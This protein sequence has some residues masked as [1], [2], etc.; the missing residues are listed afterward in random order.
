MPTPGW[1][2]RF[3][4]T[5]ALR[6]SPEPLCCIYH[7][8]TDRGKSSRGQGRTSAEWDLEAD[9]DIHA[10]SCLPCHSH[11]G[12]TVTLKDQELWVP[13]MQAP[14]RHCA[15]WDLGHCG[16]VQPLQFIRSKVLCVRAR[17]AVPD[18]HGGS[19]SPTTAKNFRGKEKPNRQ[20]YRKSTPT[21]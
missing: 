6:T 9:C 15:S 12:R 5:R 3:S 21:F 4:M 1:L 20:K 8:K 19:G 17:R 10:V 2:L 18:V 16:D 11:H 7:V 13:H 14:G